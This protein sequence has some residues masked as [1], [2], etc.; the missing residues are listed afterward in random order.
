MRGYCNGLRDSGLEEI[1]SSG[2]G[3]VFIFG[4]CLRGVLLVC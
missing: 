1:G 3:E 2:N 4:I